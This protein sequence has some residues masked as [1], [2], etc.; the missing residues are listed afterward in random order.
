MHAHA[1][2]AATASRMCEFVLVVNDPLLPEV[3]AACLW[4]LMY[5]PAA[6]CGQ[7]WLSNRSNHLPS[8][9][10]VTASM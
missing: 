2:F 7:G 5:E 4:G 1:E 3:T 10:P 9:R 8:W 6:D